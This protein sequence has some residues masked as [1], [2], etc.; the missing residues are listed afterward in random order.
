MAKTKDVQFIL[1]F[2]DKG[3]AT[4]KKAVAG[5]TK[6]FTKLAKGAKS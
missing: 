1:T 2:N 5:S 3:T 4:L 6:E